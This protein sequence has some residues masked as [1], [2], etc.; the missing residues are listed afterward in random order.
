MN[1]LKVRLKMGHLPSFKKLPHKLSITKGER[2]ISVE[3]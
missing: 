3:A 1:N 2:V